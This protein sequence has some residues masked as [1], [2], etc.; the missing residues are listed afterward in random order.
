L[1]INLSN[2]FVEKICEQKFPET[3]QIRADSGNDQQARIGAIYDTVEK[4]RKPQ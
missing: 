1:K 4:R 2:D 3:K